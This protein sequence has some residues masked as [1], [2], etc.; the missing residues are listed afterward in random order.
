MNWEALDASI[1][2]PAL[3]AGL[4]VIATHVPLGREVLARGIIFIDLALA[5]IAGLGVIAAASFGWEP[6]G[7]QVQAVAIAAALAGAALLYQTERRFAQIQEALIGSTF[8]LAA[9]LGILLLATNPHGGEQLRELLAGQILWVRY[10]E[11]FPVA[12]LYG[13]LLAIWFALPAVRRG[14]GFYVVFALAVTASVQVVGVYLV[15]ASLILPALAAH[16]LTGAR[17]LWLAY[18]VGAGGYAAGIATSALWDLPT[19]AVVVWSL[20]LAALAAGLLR[21]YRA[22]T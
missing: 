3:A 13:V 18:F 15:F 1:L 4:L 5:Q 12:L 17:G 11:L 21:A 6:R 20:A 14:W 10:S 22:Q 19:G 8:V 2:G 7:W 9:T 16:R